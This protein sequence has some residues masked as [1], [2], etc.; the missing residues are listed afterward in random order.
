MNEAKCPNC[1]GE[2]GFEVVVECSANNV[3]W[4]SVSDHF[5]LEHKDCFWC[6]G[7]GQI[8]DGRIREIKKM[9]RSPK[10]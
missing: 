4:Y 9:K 3:N 8:T 6:E 5:E 10:N 2:G 7:K 1:S